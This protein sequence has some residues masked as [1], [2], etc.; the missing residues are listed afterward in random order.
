MTSLKFSM[1]RSS[2]FAGNML[3]LA[4]WDEAP[5]RFPIA[6]HVGRRAARHPARGLCAIVRRHGLHTVSA[7]THN[8]A[9]WEEGACAACSPRFS[10]RY[11]AHAS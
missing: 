4:S 5:R 1:T 10:C 7:T 9:V 2:S 8:R 3:E 11:G 6:R